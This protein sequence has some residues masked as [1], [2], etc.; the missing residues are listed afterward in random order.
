MDANKSTMKVNIAFD[1]FYKIS[2]ISNMDTTICIYKI[3]KKFI[4]PLG[5]VVES[6]GS[7]SRPEAEAV[8]RAIDHD[9]TEGRHNNKDEDGHDLHEESEASLQRKRFSIK[10]TTTAE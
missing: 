4:I 7:N 9:L 5:Q 3:G 8:R 10:T 2:A 1:I 6:G